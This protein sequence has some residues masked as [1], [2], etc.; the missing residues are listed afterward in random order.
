MMMIPSVAA[1]TTTTSTI[2]TSSTSSDYKHRRSGATRTQD[3]AEIV[4]M[5]VDD[6]CLHGDDAPTEMVVSACDLDEEYTDVPDWI[7][8]KL[9]DLEREIGHLKGEIERLLTAC[10]VDDNFIQVLRDEIQMLRQMRDQNYDIIQRETN[11]SVYRGL[12]QA[13]MNY[14]PQPL[15]AVLGIVTGTALN[16]RNLRIRIMRLCND[17]S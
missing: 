5:D 13:I 9:W 12:I 3:V 10:E 4:A 1:T 7:H 11:G 8:T 15:P 17:C 14:L 6:S 16:I 2:R